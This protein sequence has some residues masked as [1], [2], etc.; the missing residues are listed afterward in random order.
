[1]FYGD[2]SST[3]LS[4]PVP[5]GLRP[6]TLNAT[7]DLPF[8]VRPGT[9]SVL[10][11][12]RLVTRI[13]LPTTDLAPVVLPLNAVE[14]TDN[15]V[16]LT[17]RLSALAED[18]YCLDWENALILSNGSVITV[19]PWAKNAKGIL[20]SWLLGQSGGPALADV[21]A[22]GKELSITS[23][24]DVLVYPLD[25]ARVAIPAL[26]RFAQALQLGLEL[27]LGRFW[28]RLEPP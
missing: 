17:L 20:E 24:S 26:D 8:P 10:Q 12:E 28:P 1:M 6:A 21:I 23:G 14:V 5:T 9:L 27:V 13:V 3:S 7:L 2:T 16:T 25:D 15:T 19:A 4:F 18:G 11:D 22:D